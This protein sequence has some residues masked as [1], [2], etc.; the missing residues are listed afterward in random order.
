MC[1]ERS[2]GEDSSDVN[3]VHEECRSLRREYSIY[4]KINSLK[5][6]HITPT[7]SSDKADLLQAHCYSQIRPDGH[8]SDSTI[9]CIDPRRKIH[10][11]LRR[12][13]S[14][15]PFNGLPVDPLHVTGKSGPKEG[16][17]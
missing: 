1:V 10:T 9:V 15:D 3:R 16:I 8:V 6:P 2:A 11:D 5:G 14:V 17:N 12:A 13:A 7:F 4:A